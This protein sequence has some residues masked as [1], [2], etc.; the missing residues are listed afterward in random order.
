MNKKTLKIVLIGVVI[1]L[2]VVSIIIFFLTPTKP[3]MLAD[4]LVEN[5]SY[6]KDNED[7]DLSLNVE[8]ETGD[9]PL[10]ICKANTIPSYLDTFASTIDNTLQRNEKSN[11]ITWEQDE[12]IVLSYNID[13]TLLTINLAQYKETIKFTSVEEFLSTYLE[14]TIAYSEPTIETGDNFQMYMMNRLIDGK[15]VRIGFGNSDYFLIENGYLRTA[16]IFLAQ[17]E[18]T[19]YVVPMID[20]VGVLESY[21]SN[22]Q[23]PK[24]IIVDTSSILT[25][26]E[27]DYQMFDI[28]LEYEN[29]I[30]NDIGTILLFSNCNQNFI[31]YTYEIS[32]VCDTEYESQL[33]TVPFRGF[34]NAIDP[35]YVKSIE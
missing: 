24:N 27:Y 7:Y 9:S 34:I 6:L 35:E 32:G 22:S 12:E 30:I 1:L 14:S 23:Y 2:I 25:I 4:E 18:K 31:Y 28:Q 17:I 15:E 29:C 19:E 33:Y 8:L 5:N 3:Q 21:L 10:Y 13:T 11:L 16:K 20:N 26:E